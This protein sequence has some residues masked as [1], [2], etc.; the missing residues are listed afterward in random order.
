[1]ANRSIRSVGATKANLARLLVGATFLALWVHLI[2]LA[3]GGA[4]GGHGLGGAGWT[5][6]FWSGVLGMGLGDIAVFAA[7]PL[8][9]ARLTVVMTQCLAAPVAA[10]AEWWWLGTVLTP[11]QIGCS[12]VILSGVALALAP[13]RAHPPRV[14]VK[15]IGVVFGVLSAFGQG[16]GAVLSRKAYELTNTAG[17]TIDGMTSTYLRILGGLLITLL[18]FALQHLYTQKRNSGL[19]ISSSGSSAPVFSPTPLSRPT[20]KEEN[21]THKRDDV[22]PRSESMFRRWR[23]ALVNGICG[24]VIGVSCYQWAL[25]TTASGIVLPIVATTPIVVVPLAYWLDGDRPTRRS[26]IGGVIAVAGAVCLSVVK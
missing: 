10:L 9:G 7:L 11:A 25:S 12:A 19:V 20:E 21:T 5:F 8:L 16:L 24:P 1:M 3:T 14:P 15:L 6:F 2:P 23:W 4:S 17:D 22:S 13:S 18:Y 26:L